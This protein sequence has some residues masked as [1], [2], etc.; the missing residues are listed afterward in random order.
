MNFQW[1]FRRHAILFNMTGKDFRRW[2]VNFLKRKINT[3]WLI[4]QDSFRFGFDLVMELVKPFI[5]QQ[6]MQRFNW[7][8]RSKIAVIMGRPPPPQPLDEELGPSM[9]E[10]RG[11]CY[12]CIEG[13]TGEGYKA[14]RNHV[15]S[16]RSICQACARHTCKY[17]LV[18]KCET[19]DKEKRKNVLSLQDICTMMYFLFI[20]FW[21]SNR[22]WIQ[23]KKIQ[24]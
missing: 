6:N 3:S 18:Q 23:K 12:V 14:K 19:C 7:L 1:L 10:K 2:A 17:Y 8:V 9:S 20:F 16:N 15:V 13:I 22:S 11:R 21:L 5:E 4:K 24:I